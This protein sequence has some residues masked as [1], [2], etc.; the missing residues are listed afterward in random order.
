MMR[1]VQAIAALGIW[2]TASAA[3]AQTPSTVTL[4]PQNPAR[5]DTAFH[6]GWLGVN[7]SELAPDWNSWYDAGAFGVAAGRY[8][9]PHLKLELEV[10]TTTQ[11]ELYSYPANPVV[12]RPE[13]NQFRARTFGGLVSYQFFENTWFHPFAGI[14]VDVVR[15]SSRVTLPQF[16][17]RPLP[18]S[19][20]QV[21]P[22]ETGDWEA[23]THARP[24]V[25]GGFKWY[26]AGRAFIRSDLRASFSSRQF[27]SVVWR[28]GVGFDF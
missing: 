23:T 7:K 15:E 19:S 5:W 13:L 18:D 22:E 16:V 8:L 28:G 12:F 11:A 26:V 4:Q 2:L 24:V 25:T 3:Y 6:V 20:F 1:T 17:A 27:E 14:G 21:V 10:G 9:T